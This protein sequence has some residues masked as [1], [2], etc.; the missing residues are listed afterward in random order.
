VVRTNG[1]ER[2]NQ[3]R[4]LGRVLL[5][6]ATIDVGVVACGRSNV[7]FRGDAYEGGGDEAG[8]GGSAG[9]GGLTTGGTGGLVSTGGS[10]GGGGSGNFGNGGTLSTG[11]FPV[12]GSGAFAGA[13]AAGP[14]P[15]ACAGV[16]ASCD[17]F[18]NFSTL[19]T[20]TWGLGAFTGGVSVFGSGLMY[21]D[22]AN[23]HVA[24]AVNDYGSG[25]ILWF[26]NCADLSAYSGV[27]FTVSGYTTFTGSVE[28]MPLTNSD[29]PWQL[30][31][32][33]QK[34]AC[35]S[36][37]PA[38]PWGDCLAPSALVGLGSSSPQYVYWNAISG[39]YP[40]LWNQYTSP[41]ELV[42]LEWHFP[43]DPSFGP[44]TVDMTLDDVS[45][46]GGTGN[47]CGPGIGGTGGMGGIGG[48]GGVAG[49]AGWSGMPGGDGGMSG[50][51][52]SSGAGG[53]AGTGTTAGEGGVSSG[54]DGAGGV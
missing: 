4:G 27:S 51:A 14:G 43:Y 17:S 44:Y 34:G 26:T 18:T 31:P 48:N 12:G 15:F 54:G 5:L 39:G 50:G 36:D 33:D 16:K 32:Q 29:Y 22:G 11:G 1:S 41:G 38:N 30:R 6:V 40:V 13:A 35:T 28:F 7:W 8:R 9:K 45:F 52:G 25:V 19:A 46:I 10:G 2:R 42:G 3:T 49:S 21:T 37:T 24:G 20:T 47:D 53:S 23:V